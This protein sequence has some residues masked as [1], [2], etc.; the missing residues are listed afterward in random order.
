[1]LS[2]TAAAAP[3]PI[4]RDLAYA[5][6]PVAFAEA[7][8]ITCDAWQADLLLSQPRKALLL[9]SRQSGKS[10]VTALKALWTA[11]YEPNSLTVIAA[12]AQRQSGEML[13]S[14][15]ALHAN[16]AGAPSLIN[17]SVLKVE[18]SNGSR[19]IA[20]PGEGRTIRGYSAPA[21]IIVDEAALIDDSLMQALR[22]ML[23]TSKNGGCLIALTTPKGRRGWFFEQWHNGDDSWTRVRVPASDCPRI[24]KEW[25]A[26]QL[27]EMGP[28]QYAE[29]FDL[30]F[31][32][33]NN[34]A[35][36]TD[37]IDAAF[38]EFPPLW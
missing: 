25:L 7:A 4:A 17:E 27:K 1:M 36:S 38:V 30:H 21:L 33:D 22:P 26:D 20:L 35:F 11:L 6:N 18:L 15:K 9:C 12:P 28:T 8:G 19:I 14:V 37:I 2:A 31:I 13:R 29:E 10:T 34:A 16:L 32:D 3:M 5:L 23:A 24:S